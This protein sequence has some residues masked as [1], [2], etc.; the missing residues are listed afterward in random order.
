[1]KRFIGLAAVLSAAIILTTALDPNFISPYN[2]MNILRWTGLFGILSLGASFVIMSGGIDLS[3]GSLVGLTG[4]LSAYFIRM[5]G[6]PIPEALAISMGLGLMAGLLHGVLVT[7]IRVQPFV[8]TLCGLFIYRGIARFITS[9]VTQGYGNGFQQLKFLAHGR[10]PA[11]LWPSGAA[12]RVIKDWSLPMPFIILLV[13][14]IVFTIFLKY[15]IYGRYILALGSNERAVRF[16]AVKT[17]RIKILTYVISAACA[18]FAGILFSLDL[19]TVQ[20]S[21]AGNMYELYAI[22]GCVVGGLSLKG[23]EGDI[24]GV[25]M[26]TAVV[27]I[28]YNAINILGISTTLEFTI[29]GLVILIG[30]SAEEVVKLLSAR[31]RL[32]ETLTQYE[33][34]EMKGRSEI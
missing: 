3:V 13:L 28:L 24:V 18:A 21:T 9:D 29:V 8:V 1:M 25:I 27:R 6:A 14:G 4:A 22:A 30:V 33:P 2:I 26:G 34:P 17:D 15:T 31:R 12:P 16:T 11:F 5:R 7:K 10:V 23:G 32:E 20:P 19:N